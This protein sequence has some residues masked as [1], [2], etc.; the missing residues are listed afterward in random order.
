MLKHQQN[1]RIKLSGTV[2]QLEL[3]AGYWVQL[4]LRGKYDVYSEEYKKFACVEVR[5]DPETEEFIVTAP[6]NVKFENWKK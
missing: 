6:N 1:P 2:E 4:L 3:K 5:V